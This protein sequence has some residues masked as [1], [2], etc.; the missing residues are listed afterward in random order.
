MLYVMSD[1]RLMDGFRLPDRTVQTTPY[2]R[3]VRT[4]SRA[5]RIGMLLLFVVWFIANWAIMQS[6]VEVPADMLNP[7]LLRAFLESLLLI[8]VCHFMVRPL[9]QAHLLGLRI[10]WSKAG[11]TLGWLILVALIYFSV[12]FSLGKL[13]VLKAIDVS[14]IHAFTPDGVLEANLSGL[15]VFILGAIQAFVILALWS[16]GYLGLQFYNNR[17]ELHKSM[18]ENRLAQLTSQLR[19]HFLFNTLNSIRALIFIDQQKAADLLTALST[20]LRDQMGAHMSM[21]ST[22]EKDWTTASRYL[23]IE[24]VRFS[25]RL[26]IEVALD[27]QTLDQKLPALTMLTLVENAIKH[28]VSVSEKLCLL[29]IRSFMANQPEAGKGRRGVP[30]ASWIL[31]IENS[32]HVDGKTSGSR[33]GLSNVRRRLE[34]MFGS[35]VGFSIRRQNGKFTVVME[36]PYV[37]STDRG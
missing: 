37:E 5:Y 15:A 10:D 28:A 7:I 8:L 18:E 23:D 22:L 35:E 2:W 34:L 4:T 33:V 17:H 24:T 30:G 26:Q 13:S 36:L 14:Q 31:E 11:R 21:E 20:L 3:S 16:V 27:P 25:D 19:P 6:I 32:F 1:P 12:S 29:S 9:L